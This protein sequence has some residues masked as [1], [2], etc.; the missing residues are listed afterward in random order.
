MAVTVHRQRCLVHRVLV[1]VAGALY[2]W[3][4]QTGRAMLAALSHMV[5]A[6]AGTLVQQAPIAAG[7]IANVLGVVAAHRR[8]TVLGGARHMRILLGAATRAKWKGRVLYS[9]SAIW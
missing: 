1:V 9:M 5:D 3:R 6:I 2:G 4:V 7:Q 8:V